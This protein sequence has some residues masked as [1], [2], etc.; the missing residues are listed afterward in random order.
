[1][2]APFFNP[3]NALLYRK[4]YPEGWWDTHI[5]D[6]PFSKLPV[7]RQADLAGLLIDSIEFARFVQEDP[8]KLITEVSF[9]GGR[10]ETTTISSELG[11]ESRYLF[12]C[13]NTRT[14]RLSD[15]PFQLPG[16]LAAERFKEEVLT[17]EKLLALFKKHFSNLPKGESEVIKRIEVIITGLFQQ[18]TIYFNQDLLRSELQSFFHFYKWSLI[19]EDLV[20]ESI[21]KMMK[22]CSR[23]LMFKFSHSVE[24]DL[25]RVIRA[26]RTYFKEKQT[27]Y[28]VSYSS[29][30]SGPFI[31]SLLKNWLSS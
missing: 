8:T 26:I 15:S 29:R 14:I 13:L 24:C 27:V 7:D 19:D 23:E 10:A 1:M 2:Q 25:Y 5:K 20:T 21:D 12:A 9:T 6:E 3:D 31:R 30:K 16:Q 4:H 18:A 22:A 28:P 11:I 17:D